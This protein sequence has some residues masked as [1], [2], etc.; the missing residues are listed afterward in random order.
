MKAEIYNYLKSV[1]LPK[2]SKKDNLRY[3]L[4]CRSV[5]EEW[6]YPHEGYKCSKHLDMPSYGLDRKQCYECNDEEKK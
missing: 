6:F 4:K 1:D 2:S 3:C 5:W